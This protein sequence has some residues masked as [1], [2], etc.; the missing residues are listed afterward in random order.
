MGLLLLS[1][2]VVGDQYVVRKPEFIKTLP[3]GKNST[4]VLA[5]TIPDPNKIEIAY[6][7]TSQSLFILFFI[8]VVDYGLIDGREDQ[9]IVPSGPGVASGDKDVFVEDQEYVI[10]QKQSTMKYLVKVRFVFDV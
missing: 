2:V 3:Q 8:V 1:D 9:V 10:Y 4:L 7:H 6:A 5:K